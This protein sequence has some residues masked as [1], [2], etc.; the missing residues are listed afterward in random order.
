MKYRNPLRFIQWNRKSLFNWSAHNLWT[1]K[2]WGG[3]I[4]KKGWEPLIYRNVREKLFHHQTEFTY[5][6]LTVTLYCVYL[7]SSCIIQS[8]HTAGQQGHS[9]LL[10]LTQVH[11]H[12]GCGLHKL[13]SSERNTKIRHQTSQNSQKCDKIQDSVEIRK[14]ASPRFG[15]LAVCLP[16]RSLKKP[17]PKEER[18]F[19]VPKLSSAV[20]FALTG[21]EEPGPAL[22]LTYEK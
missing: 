2:L 16:P 13:Q 17:R 4:S 8:S 5:R 15:T 18:A 21:G 11:W 1:Y 19:L 12:S 14:S 3:V 20:V 6:K 22:F 10:Y 9:A 7:T